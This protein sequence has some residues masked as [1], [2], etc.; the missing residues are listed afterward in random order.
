MPQKI[1]ITPEERQV[2]EL[3]RRIAGSNAENKDLRKSLTRAREE[4]E[5]LREKFDDLLA[6]RRPVNPGPLVRPCA[7]KYHGVALAEWS[8]WHVAEKIEARKV[9]GLNRFSPEIATKRA[10]HCAYSTR[11]LYRHVR[12]SYGVDSMVLVLGGDFITGYLHE[13]LVA[14][15]YMGPVEEGIFAQKLLAECLSVVADEK[16]LKKLRV[17]CH[18]GNHGRTTK[19]MQFKNDFSTSYETWIYANLADKFADSKRIVFEIPESDVH[20]TEVF[21]GWNLRTFH[22]H[23][24]KY[25]DGIGGLTIPLNKWEAKQD[26]TTP[27]QFNLMGHYHFYSEPNGKT[28]LNGSL[29][30]YDEYAASHGFP[31]QPPLQSF[32]LLDVGRRMIAQRM[33]IFCE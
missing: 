31:F 14:T 4:T 17:I 15:N 6:L 12:K 20:Y 21:P 29:K 27:A 26:A 30:G 23:Q 28:T 25:S 18:R 2:A 22:G 11:A 16:S 10:H 33:P 9:N 24:V 19:K 13:E 7:A 5:S 32:N 8:D 1:D 3:E